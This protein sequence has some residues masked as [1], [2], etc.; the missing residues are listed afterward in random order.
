MRNSKSVS[1]VQFEKQYV[2][3]EC[4]SKTVVTVLKDDSSLRVEHHLSWYSGYSAL[5]SCSV[6]SNQGSEAV[7]LE[8]LSSFS[9]G[10]IT[11]YEPD[12]APGVLI[13]HRL[14]SAWSAEGRL[15]SMP[16]EDLQLEPS[17][18]GYSVRCE[19]Y[20]QIGSM[21]VRK[22]FPFAVIEDTKSKVSWGVQIAC[23]S[24]WQIEVGRRDDALCISGGLAD[25]EFGHW[26]KKV[27]PG[28]TFMTPKAILSVSA[29]GVDE[30]S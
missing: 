18:S 11:P 10:E 1:R 2:V 23:P 12:D 20:G 15:E 29:G 13:L 14:R 3:E 28:E 25:R 17:W 7:C 24:S 27:G 8:M 26:L 6:F 9:M 21:P 16:V 30:V 4:D 22:Y 19:R 5:E